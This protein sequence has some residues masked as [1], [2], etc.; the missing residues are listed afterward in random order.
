MTEYTLSAYKG[1]QHSIIGDEVERHAIN[2]LR[3]VRGESH[4][5]RVLTAIADALDNGLTVTV[6]IPS[7]TD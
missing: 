4:L 3:N 6:H 1:V 5:Q 2:S 7:S